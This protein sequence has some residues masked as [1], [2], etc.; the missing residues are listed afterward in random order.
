MTDR[1]SPFT[2]KAFH[3]LLEREGIEHSMSRAHT[4]RDNRY[5]ET[6]WQTMKT[7]I[8]PV[9]EMTIAEYRMILEYYEYY[10]NNLRPHSALGYRPPLQAV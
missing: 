7:E 4:P 6:F 10:Y 2:G 9:K 5:I 8:G 1:G 3:E